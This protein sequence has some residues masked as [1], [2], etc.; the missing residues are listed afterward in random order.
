MNNGTVRIPVHMGEKLR[1]YKKLTNAYRIYLG[2]KPTRQEIAAQ[3]GA[4]YKAVVELEKASQMTN[5]RSLDSLLVVDD[6]ITVGDTIPDCV[7]IESDVLETVQ[8]EQLK[9]I[10]W[11]MVDNLPEEQ[12]EVIRQRYQEK[13]TPKTIG[14]S[15]GI[16]IENA[17]QIEAKAMR[18]LRG[19]QNVRLLKPFVDDVYSMGLATTSIEGFNRTWTSSTERAALMLCEKILNKKE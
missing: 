1:E 5:L 10:L 17:K 2:R 14:E 7:D 16:S 13:K 18:S 11:S 6:S 8:Q 19:S 3:M 9:T 15:L 4:P 12:G